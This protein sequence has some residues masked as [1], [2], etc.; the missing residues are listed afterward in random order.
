MNARKIIALLALMVPVLSASAQLNPSRAE[1]Q[2]IQRLLALPDLTMRFQAAPLDDVLRTLCEASDMAFIGLPTPKG[3]PNVDMTI[4]GNPYQALLLVSQTYGYVPLYEN[5]L[6]HFSPIKEERAKLYPKVYKLKNINVNEINVNQEA[7]NKAVSRDTS[8]ALPQPVNSTAFTTDISKV[9][10]DIKALLELD[11]NSLAMNEKDAALPQVNPAA[12]L[13]AG[14]PSS[15]LATRLGVNQPIKQDNLKGRIIADPD[16]NSLF[17]IATKEHHQ[18]IETYLNAIDIPRKL[19]LLET[20]FVEVS[21]DPSTY[22]GVD[23]SSALGESGYAGTLTNKN[24]VN[25][26]NPDIDT[27]GY[28]QFLFDANLDKAILTGPEL[29]ATL[30]AISSDMDSRSLQHPSQVTVNNRQVVLRNVTQYPFT[31]GSTS[32]S[33]NNSTTTTEET[34]YVPIGTT[35][36]LLP[37]IL[38]GENVELNIMIN[39][40]DLLGYQDIGG[41][42][43][44]ITSARDYSGQAIVGSGNTLAIGGL[45][46]LNK[47][48]GTNKIPVLGDIPVLGYLF[49]NESS[50]DSKS[51]LVMFITATIL[52]GYTGGVKSNDKVDEMLRELDQQLESHG[53]ASKESSTAPKK[54]YLLG[55]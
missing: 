17:I 23:W 13:L 3:A 21:N 14:T 10:T 2:E 47:T 49:R 31:S 12:L 20:R 4:K 25:I 38:D 7:M 6:W 22:F 44:P 9:I 50:E 42:D 48:K 35:V 27:G 46:A 11:P 39:V 30:H 34:E 36:S 28:S 29:V 37:R 53:E 40:S 32:N 8:S 52:D 45:D 33:T 43:I 54:K 19:V 16:Q 51:N 55:K 18:W 5:G 41:A 26:K 15:E 1:E 24:S